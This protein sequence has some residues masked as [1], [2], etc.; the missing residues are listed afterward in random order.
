MSA[1]KPLKSPAKMEP[2]SAPPGA[3]LRERKRQQTRER[4][5]RGAMELFLARGFEATTLDHSA[6][7]PDIS[8]SSFPESSTSNRASRNYRA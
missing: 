2:P 8:R 7:A 1:A 5:T 3:G 4:L 6:A